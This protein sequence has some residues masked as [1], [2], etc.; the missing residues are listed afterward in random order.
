MGLLSDLVDKSSYSMADF[1]HDVRGLFGGSATKSGQKVNEESALRYITVYS[2]VRVLAETLG[3]LPIFVHRSLPNGGSEK[4][5]DHPVFGLL[6]DLPN[7]EMTTQTW[8]ETMMGH[9]TLS[10][11]CYS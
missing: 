6:H 11:N 5:R 3:S 8:R 4:V 9:L 7:D 2:C 10:G 1:N